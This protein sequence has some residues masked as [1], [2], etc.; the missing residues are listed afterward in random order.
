MVSADTAI[1][2]DPWWNPAIE[3]QAEDRIY[4]I[5]QKSKVTVYRLIAAN[6]I[7]EKI[8]ELQETKRR[9]FDDIVEGHDIPHNI[10]MDD[11]RML[12]DN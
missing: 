1:I 2:Y 7:E 5:G 11:I 6:T 4:R 9:L 10:T 12:L 3:K 8:R